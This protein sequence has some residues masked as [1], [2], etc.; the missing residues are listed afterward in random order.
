MIWLVTRL[1]YFCSCSRVWCFHNLQYWVNGGIGVG[2]DQCDRDFVLIFCFCF[3]GSQQFCPWNSLF[4]RAHTVNPSEKS[5]HKQ[6]G[7]FWFMFYWRRNIIRKTW[8]DHKFQM[9]GWQSDLSQ[10]GLICL[11]PHFLLHPRPL[12]LRP[13]C[14]LNF[15]W[16]LLLPARQ[17]LYN[18]AVWI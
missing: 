10:V 3:S 4:F 7:V 15:F 11:L 18:W 8:I 1:Y 14:F 6:M 16:D 13:I 12:M 5:L 2:K 17:T 9:C